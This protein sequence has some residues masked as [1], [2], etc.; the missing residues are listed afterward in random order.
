MP[1]KVSLSQLILSVLSE[2]N[3]PCSTTELTL[4]CAFDRPNAH[5][6][7][8]TILRNLRRDGL[9]SRELRIRPAEDRKAERGS[10]WVAMWSLLRGQGGG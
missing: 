2:S 5:H 3:I 7:V 8:S 9:V 6:Q 10:K 4:L 1:T